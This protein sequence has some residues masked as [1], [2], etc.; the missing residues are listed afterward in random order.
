[1]SGIFSDREKALE[2]KW[3]HDEELRFQVLSR[4][5]HLLGLW[6]AAEMGLTPQAAEDYA[7]AVVS[8]ELAKDGD[9]AV[10]RKVQADLAAAKVARTDH[11]IRLKMEELLTLAKTEVSGSR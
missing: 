11:L 3:A 2:D 4:R 7:K 6:A 5:N 9:D 10:F 1:M 8:A